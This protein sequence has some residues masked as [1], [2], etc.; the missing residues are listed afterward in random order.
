M[1]IVMA[2]VALQ[3]RV[4]GLSYANLRDTLPDRFLA[5]RTGGRTREGIA[6]IGHSD[7]EET[8]CSSPLVRFAP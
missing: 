7:L 3:K 5:R 8:T 6:S 1:Q 4:A 2:L